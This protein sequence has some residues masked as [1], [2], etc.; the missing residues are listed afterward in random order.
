GLD[1]RSAAQASSDP[2]RAPRWAVED[3]EGRVLAQASVVVLAAGADLPALV[4]PLGLEGLPWQTR[5]GQI[6]W[7][8]DGPTLRQPLTGQGYAV[9]LPDGRLLFGATSAESDRI[10]PSDA[11][12]EHNRS[13]LEMLTGHRP[14][15]GQPGGGSRVSRRLGMPDRLPVVG[16]LPRRDADTEVARS[17]RRDQVRFIPRQPGLFVCGGFGSRGLTWAPLAAQV[18]CAWLEGTPMPLE[19]D[20]LDAIDPARWQVRAYRRAAVGA[21]EIQTPEDASAPG[22]AT[23][24]AAA[25]D[26]GPAA[27]AS[28]A[29]AGASPPSPP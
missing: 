16:P 18:I 17:S 23:R 28:A 6:D 7:C 29:A 13:R 14:R 8:R 20:L 27:C 2:A 1:V 21:A 5:R 12:T 25:T 4:G 24:Q 9:S 15:P 3:P 11:D 26:P 22:G 10:T 19:A